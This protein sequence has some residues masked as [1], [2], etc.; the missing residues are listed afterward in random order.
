[1]SLALRFL[2]KIPLD[3]PCYVQILRGLTAR[4]RGNLVTQ[5]TSHKAFAFSI[6]Y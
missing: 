2:V 3:H 4:L 5:R 6:I 1:M